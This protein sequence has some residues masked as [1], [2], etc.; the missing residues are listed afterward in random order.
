MRNFPIILFIGLCF[1]VNAQKKMSIDEAISIALKHNFDIQVA[2]NESEIARINN[3]LGNAGMLPTLNIIGSANYELNQENQTLQNGTVNN[4]N[5]V[6]SSSLNA[7]AQLSWLLFDGGKMFVSKRKLNEIQSLGELQFKNQV[8]SVIFQLIAAYYDLVRQK[9]QL[10]S[11]NEVLKYNKERVKIA[12]IAFKA[13]SL[14]KSDLLSARIDLNV[15]MENAINQEFE[16]QA[17]KKALNILLALNPNNEIETE[18]SIPLMFNPEKNDLKDK[19]FQKNASILSFEKKIDISRLELK[20]NERA[21]LPTFNI[22][23]GYYFSQSNNSQGT[24][25]KNSSLGPQIGGTLS[26]PLY[27]AGENQRKTA[28]SKVQLSTNE[29][30]LEQ[31]KLQLTA[32]FENT[33]SN[34]ENQQ[35]L[36]EI[37]KENNQLAKENLEISLQR[38]R[39]GQTTSLEVRQAQTDYVQSSTRLINFQ[40]NLKIAESKLKQLVAGL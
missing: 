36:F 24:T 13:G 11:I 20:E 10:I 16:I 19:L 39:F 2:H 38:L 3:T 6:S 32:E 12:E 9:Q 21:Y 26:I 25:L 15:L 30:D 18:D 29:N 40:Y 22:K 31:T 27:S 33:F 28:A 8:Q 35:K 17:S 5:A 37:E 23:G 4:F 7:G 1:V 14:L 34:F